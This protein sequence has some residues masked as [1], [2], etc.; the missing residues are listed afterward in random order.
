MENGIEDGCR[1]VALECQFASCHFVEHRTEGEQVSP[2]V[3]FLT[4]RLLGRHVGNRAHGGS[5]R[6]E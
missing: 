5:R 2:R 4:Q 6:G 3:E 1:C